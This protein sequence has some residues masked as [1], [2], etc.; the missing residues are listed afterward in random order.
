MRP[1]LPA[2]MSLAALLVVAAL[3]RGAR[4][5]AREA[6][7]FA[8]ALAGW[9]A[10][11]DPAAPGQTRALPVA[12][13]AVRFTY[14]THDVFAYEAELALARTAAV[15]R[16]P[17]VMFAG[18]RGD[19]ARVSYLGRAQ[20]GVRLR[21]GARFVPTLHLAAGVQAHAAGDARLL[22][23]G[24]IVM[25]GPAPALRWAPVASAGLGLDYRIDAHWVAGASIT[26]LT[27]LAPGDTG[28][29]SIEGGAHVSYFWYPHW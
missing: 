19:L 23:P 12:G 11:G 15:A 1:A 17:D 20:A 8:H 29:R 4:A 28:F 6:S 2:V 18:F 13:T 5:D 9:A 10:L 27:A 21:L 16:F 24:D 3:P 22:L 7:L 25:P 14:A 26:A